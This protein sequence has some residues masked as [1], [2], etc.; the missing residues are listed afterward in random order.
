M[1]DV[2]TVVMVGGSSLIPCVQQL[3]KKLFP[4][5]HVVHEDPRQNGRGEGVERALTA[6]SKGLALYD[7][8]VARQ[9]I[10]PFAYGFWDTATNKVI[11]AAPKWSSHSSE[12][13]VARLSVPSGASAVTLTLVQE[14]VEPERVLNVVNVPVT[15]TNGDRTHVHARV[16]TSDGSLYPDIEVLD[17]GTG[18][19]LGVFRVADLSDRV[20]R[21]LVENDDNAIRWG[22]AALATERD[23]SYPEVVTLG[24]GDVVEYRL[25]RPNR[26]PILCSGTIERIDKIADGLRYTEVGHWDLTRWRFYIRVGEYGEAV[27]VPQQLTDIKL[28]RRGTRARHKGR[29]R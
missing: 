4:N 21:E 2:D 13:P 10:T 1:D 17:N 6:V 26:A 3:L 14:M 24:V 7:E 9:G 23:T 19:P 27:V 18:Q 25:R 12:R 11:P 28:A 20:L 15:G 16:R 22:G 8:T 5:A 29:I